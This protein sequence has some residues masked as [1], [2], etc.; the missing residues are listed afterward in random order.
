MKKFSLILTLL[1][2]LFLA[3]C[4]DLT[5]ELWI[6][7][8]G[9]GRMKF[10]IGLAENLVAMIE[11]SG[12]SAEFCENAIKDMGKLENNALVLSLIHI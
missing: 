5:E 6:N 1:A 7:P 12:K 3:G 10:T 9:S 4:Y 8:D 11:S 2:S